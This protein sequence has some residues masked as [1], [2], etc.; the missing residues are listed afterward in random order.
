MTKIK[1]SK[2]KIII[3][4]M[5]IIRRT[6]MIKLKIRTRINWNSTKIKK[7]RRIM[8][9]IVIM[10]MVNKEIQMS[11]A[12]KLT[13]RMI[14]TLRMMKTLIKLKRNKSKDNNHRKKIKRSIKTKLH[15][16]DLINNI[17]QSKR[18]HLYFL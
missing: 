9:I 18:T 11:K 17:L 13:A 16:N 4:Q 15:P 7:L 10:K 14:W 6:K 2:R 5:I 1:I 8:K 12:M 3:S